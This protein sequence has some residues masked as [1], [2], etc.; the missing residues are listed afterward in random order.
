MGPMTRIMEYVG[1]RKSSVLPVQSAGGLCGEAVLQ[2][3]R[4]SLRTICPPGHF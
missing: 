4:P 3:A 1:G 2:T